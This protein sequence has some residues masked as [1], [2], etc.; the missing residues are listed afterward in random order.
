MASIMKNDKQQKALLDITKWLEDIQKIDALVANIEDG[1][2]AGITTDVGKK[3]GIDIVALEEKETERLLPI[4][5]AARSSLAKSVKSTA[6][7]FS[8][9]LDS[10]EQCLLKK[11]KKDDR[12]QSEDAINEAE[13]KG[14][15]I[16]DVSDSVD[17]FEA[18]TELDDV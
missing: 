5:N 2:I 13:P 14:D 1:A 4:L 3:R 8:I 17:D 6:S 7:K 10:D 15:I 16:S 9:Q 18:E 11:P 12:S